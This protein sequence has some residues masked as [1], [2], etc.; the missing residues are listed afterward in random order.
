M[1]DGLAEAGVE[2]VGLTDGEAGGGDGF[3]DAHGDFA[4]VEVTRVDREQII[5]AAEGNRDERNLGAEGKERCS[6]KER[7]DGAVGCA[8]ALGKDE[9]GHPGA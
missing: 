3:A 7:L 1:L 2:F 6:G 5:D 9:E 4:R 8:G